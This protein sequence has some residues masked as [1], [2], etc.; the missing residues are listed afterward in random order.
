MAVIS[1]QIKMST[2]QIEKLSRLNEPEDKIQ[3]EL[4]KERLASEKRIRNTQIRENIRRR[5]NYVPLIMHLIKEFSMD[6]SIEKHIQSEE[7]K[8]KKRIRKL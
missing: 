5:H 8:R 1:D 6:G 7:E 3:I 2:D 4:L